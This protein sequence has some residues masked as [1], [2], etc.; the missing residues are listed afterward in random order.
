MLSFSRQPALIKILILLLLKM[1]LRIQLNALD[2]IHRRIA[3][4]A[5]SLRRFF[6][7]TLLLHRRRESPPEA[8][9]NAA[10]A[11]DTDGPL[12][13]AKSSIRKKTAHAIAPAPDVQ[14][15]TQPAR[16][17][18]LDGLRAIAVCA[19]LLFHSDLSWAQGGYLGVD[20][21]F[22]ISGFLI[23]GLLAN[24]SPHRSAGQ[25]LSFYW[26]RAKRLL[27][28][29]WLMI[30]AMVIVASLFAIDALP[31][32]RNDALASFFYITNWELITRETSYFE[33]LG[34]Q[35]L[36]M[37]LWSLAIEEQFYLL[38][39]P[40]VLWGLPR[41]GR[42]WMAIIALVLAI[43]SAAWMALMSTKMGY[44][45]SQADPSRLYFGTDTHG[46][47][48]LFGAALGLLWRPNGPFVATGT[49]RLGKPFVLAHGF[50]LLFGSA[51]GRRW[52]PHR[53]STAVR[54]WKPLALGLAALAAT[55][56][57]FASLGEETP[58]LYPWGLLVSAMASAALI[59]A[60]THS[61]SVFGLWLDNRVMRWIGDRSYGIYLWHWPIFMLMRPGVDLPTLPSEVVAIGRVALSIA[62]AAL[63]YAWI[64]APIRHGLLERIWRNLHTPGGRRN[65]A[66]R[67]GIALL[68]GVLVTFSAVA[69][70]LLRAPNHETPA[71]DVRAVLDVQ[72]S[73]LPDTSTLNSVAS[74]SP[75]PT[76]V[77]HTPTL[78]PP[79]KD[80]RQPSATPSYTGGDLTAVG[81]SVLLG[82]SRL[83][84]AT[85][86]GVD[87]HATIGWQ[88]ANVL[89]TIRSLSRARQ[90]RPVVLV[91]LGTNGY[92][93]E[94][95]LRQI[96]SLLTNVSRVL[97]VN[98]HVPRRWMDA[99]DA[100]FD[101]VVADYPNVVLV[102]WRKASDGHRKFFVSDGVHLTVK[103]QR[104][105]I[106]AIMDAGR[107]ASTPPLG[108]A[109]NG[110]MGIAQNK[111]KP[112]LTTAPW[113]TP[114]AAHGAALCLKL[115]DSAD[116]ACAA[117]HDDNCPLPATPFAF[118]D[119]SVG[120]LFRSVQDR[121]E[122]PPS[123]F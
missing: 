33:T 4:Y 49:S 8:S 83:L 71:P 98:A 40:L 24:Q 13:T 68:A 15:Q 47:P 63:S 50:L 107:F 58:W 99:N 36:L 43:A 32:L 23:T 118:S 45:A 21:F 34:R 31:R 74:S 2:A 117:R 39:A 35:P 9:G 120:Q 70:V 41:L 119:M 111:N 105:F 62:I 38:W 95:Q 109:R 82:S 110:T 17:R 123:I 93:T 55:L 121:T 79:P 5:Q 67:R 27:P 48:L 64:E 54:A 96:L 46:F 22:V 37:H 11:S 53:W 12:Q 16:L 69:T 108:Q 52:W 18:G 57:L 94:N 14:P 116:R 80:T 75:G 90:L 84:A 106:A 91:H 59:M 60:A 72:P 44:P 104:A 100:L 103:G 51:L 101:R 87:I 19:V 61:G 102:D 78:P 86:Q 42:G 89:A 115:T 10:T 114:W 3:G 97:L 122:L 25:L 85:L 56:A 113:I 76:P 73:D 81:D 77:A 26:R 20:L 30:A 7:P 88:A 65:S 29:V 28:A 112:P 92:V 1:L 66:W 6:D